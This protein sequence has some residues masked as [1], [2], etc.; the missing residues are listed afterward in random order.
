MWGNYIINNKEELARGSRSNLVTRRLLFLSEF[1]LVALG[2]CWLR[3]ITVFNLWKHIWIGTASLLNRLNLFGNCGGFNRG[4][5]RY[6]D[7]DYLDWTFGILVKNGFTHSF[8]I[9]RAESE[10]GELFL[11]GITLEIY[12]AYY[13]LGFKWFLPNLIFVAIWRIC[14]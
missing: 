3:F 6:L 2:N 8:S 4:I 5:K 10:K 14:T 11:Q 7:F 1:F 12:S 9:F 13:L